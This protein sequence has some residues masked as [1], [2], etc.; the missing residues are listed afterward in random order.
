MADVVDRPINVSW[1]AL[2]KICPSCPSSPIDL[3]GNATCEMRLW[4]SECTVHNFGG[5]RVTTDSPAAVC[6]VLYH[7]Q[8]YCRLKMS[9]FTKECMA[10]R[11][12]S[13]TAP[14]CHTFLC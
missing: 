1:L 2:E 9:K 13:D 4:L 14:G 10:I 8:H 7:V 6:V 11:T 5:V 12:L 3:V